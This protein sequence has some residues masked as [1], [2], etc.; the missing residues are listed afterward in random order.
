MANELGF[1]KYWVARRVSVKKL[2]A[3][4]GGGLLV[5]MCSASPSFALNGFINV[6]GCQNCQTSADFS[7]AATSQAQALVKVGFYAVTSINFPETA[8]VRVNGTI[9]MECTGTPCTIKPGAPIRLSNV[10][11]T[12]V[13]ASGNSL[14]GESESAL[15]A[16]FTA[17]DQMLF[18]NFRTQGKLSKVIPIPPA[19]GT[20]PIGNEVWDVDTN[21]GINVALGNMNV[22]PATLPAGTIIS[23]V[24]ADGTTAQ[25]IR[26]NS[27]PSILWVYV[28]GSM[29]D[30]NGNP[31]TP[32][33]G[34]MVPN[35][36]TAGAGGGNSQ[37][38]APNPA[39]ITITG[40]EYC[41]MGVTLSNG[42]DT[43][44]VYIFYVPC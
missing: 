26:T 5:W 7:A 4:V 13:D 28:P 42:V 10:T 1:A 18:G 2:C 25:F 36:N 15:E 33:S 12:F 22:N 17:I 19:Y 20:T 35:P 39:T 16:A 14:A 32:I 9:R 34:T 11:T 3:A 6:T 27:V 40:T 37:P 21:T 41:Q 38:A 29:R 24:W 44:Y 43:I 8:Y 31:I 30:K 23:V